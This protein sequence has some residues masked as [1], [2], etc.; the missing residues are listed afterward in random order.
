MRE[1]VPVLVVTRDGHDD[2]VYPADQVEIL[3]V[4]ETKGG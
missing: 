3:I 1:G 4:G 2:E